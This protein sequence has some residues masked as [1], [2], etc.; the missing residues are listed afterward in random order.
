MNPEYFFIYLLLFIHHSR[1]LRV[2]GDI[3]F[4]FQKAAILI[5]KIS[6]KFFQSVLTGD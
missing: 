3:L 2:A 6:Q 4:K 1:H 5:E